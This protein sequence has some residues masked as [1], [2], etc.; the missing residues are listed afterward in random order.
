MTR[1]VARELA[2]SGVTVNAV[3]PGI[4]ETELINE[5]NE[6]KR[7]R[8]LSMIPLGRFGTPEDVA[9]LVAFL[10]SDAAGYITAQVFCV[11]GGLHV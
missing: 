3:A 6:S 1:A 9:E 5:M 4:I 2:A 11:D 7:D 8:Q 10:A